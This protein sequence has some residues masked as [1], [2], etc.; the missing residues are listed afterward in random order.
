MDI[1]PEKIA[2]FYGYVPNFHIEIRRSSQFV[3]ISMLQYLKY[4]F[5]FFIFRRTAGSNLPRFF[6]GVAGALRPACDKEKGTP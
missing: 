1:L 3:Y 2:A 4:N 5:C 6:A